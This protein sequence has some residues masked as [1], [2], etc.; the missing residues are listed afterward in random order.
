MRHDINNAHDDRNEAQ[1]KQGLR[2]PNKVF[3]IMWIDGMADESYFVRAHRIIK[4]WHRCQQ[5]EQ[6]Q[7]QQQQEKQQQQQRQIS[8]TALLNF[9]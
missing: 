8:P 4:M 5:Q 9:G 2:Q 1:P 6:Q 7:Q 3:H